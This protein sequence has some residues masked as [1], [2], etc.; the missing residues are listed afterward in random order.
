MDFE[1]TTLGEIS[2]TQN[3]AYPRIPSLGNIQID[4]STETDGGGEGLG[5]GVGW[6]G[7]GRNCLM[8]RNF[9]LE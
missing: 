9:T 3:V 2:Q 5:V 1:N 4:K 7:I 8:V 6:G